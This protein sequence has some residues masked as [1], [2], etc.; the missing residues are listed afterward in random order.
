VKRAFNPRAAKIL[1]CQM[2]SQHLAASTATATLEFSAPEQQ[3]TES[4]E[5]ASILW[6]KVISNLLC[7]LVLQRL[8]EALFSKI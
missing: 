1:L 4:T 2:R 7:I 8:K 3:P 6:Q 5:N